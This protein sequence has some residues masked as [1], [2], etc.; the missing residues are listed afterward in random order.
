MLAALRD[1]QPARKVALS[2][3]QMPL[4]R[5]LNL[6]TAK[7]ILYVA[8]VAEHEVAQGNAYAEQVRAR[9]EAE[10]AGFVVISAAIEA[11]IA[12]LDPEEKL[13]FLEELGA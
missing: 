13:A 9:A 11:E 10:G 8:N 6:L 4:F 12:A 3:E 2:E 1:G 5:S 7:P